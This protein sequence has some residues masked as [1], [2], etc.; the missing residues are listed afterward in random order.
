MLCISLPKLQTLGTPLLV[1]IHG[2]LTSR[3][4]AIQVLSSLSSTLD[5]SIFSSSIHSLL[6][7]GPLTSSRASA[8]VTLRYRPTSRS[9]S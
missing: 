7:D 2:D 6:V 1:K 5:N 9:A 8:A 4:G 3:I